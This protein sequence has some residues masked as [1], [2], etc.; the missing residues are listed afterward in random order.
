M[1]ITIC[2]NGSMDTT[3]TFF[4]GPIRHLRLVLQKWWVV[5][6][7]GVVCSI[8]IRDFCYSS[9]RA[10]S[11]SS[12]QN[13][14]QYHYNISCGIWR[15]NNFY[16][17]WRVFKEEV[18]FPFLR[19]YLTVEYW[20]F[21][22]TTIQYQFVI[23]FCRKGRYWRWALEGNGVHHWRKG[24]EPDLT[25]PDVTSGILESTNSN[26]FGGNEMEFGYGRWET[27]VLRHF[28]LMAE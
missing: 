28:I 9:Q 3:V 17:V 14:A 23:D 11:R 10:S 16:K 12:S 15:L 18:E 8:H 25:E 5:I 13:S 21:R 27:F 2:T 24:S 22:S 26:H 19:E 1:P 20:T 7:V 6:V 4:G